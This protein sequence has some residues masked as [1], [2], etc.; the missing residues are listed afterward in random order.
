MKAQYLILS[1]LLAGCAVGPEYQRPE[2]ALQ[3]RFVAGNAASVGQV[4][5]QQWWLDYKDPMLTRLVARGMAQNLDVM[6]ASEAIRQAQA[7]LRKT[8]VNSAV[9]GALTAQ[10][11]TSGGDAIDGTVT[12]NSGSLGAALVLDFFGG[13][14]REREAATASLT[15]AK[16]EAETVRLAWLAEL[17]SAY[18][19]AR[20]YQE[21][22]ALTRTTIKTREDTVEI[23]R[24]QFDAGAATEYEVAEAQALL[25]TARASLPQYAALFDANVYA[26]ATLLNEP[27]API[28]TQMQKGAPQLSS[29]GGANTGVPADLLRNRPDVRRAEADLAAAVA[30]VGVAEAALYPSLS[31]SGTVSRTEITDSW[32]FGPQLSL[33]VFN[34]GALRASRDA[35]ISAAKQAEIAWRGA[36]ASAVEDVQVAQSNLTRYRQRASLLQ[37]AARDY[38]RALTLAQQNYRNGAIT[39]LDLLETDRNAATAKISAAS[40][41]LDAAQAWATLKIATGA[42]SAATEHL[43]N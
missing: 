3:T 18:S 15:A 22:L 30:A 39:L 17:L 10:Q 36:V 7:N 35:E 4:A 29:P 27:A 9:D 34:Q 28:L 21:V 40:A 13:L 33:P 25:S 11:T 41:V 12:S 24:S 42:G 43:S 1:L 2:V 31:L 14:R 6:A 19:G 38:D 5:T 8:G 37:T 16:A 32:S 26:I 20:Y 23:T